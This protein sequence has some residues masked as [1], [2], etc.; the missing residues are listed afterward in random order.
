MAIRIASFM[1]I[2]DSVFICTERIGKFKILNCPHKSPYSGEMLVPTPLVAC[3]MTSYTP[4][5]SLN[6]IIALSRGKG[7]SHLLCEFEKE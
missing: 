6:P 7:V 1:P 4:H 5:L 3:D 2:L